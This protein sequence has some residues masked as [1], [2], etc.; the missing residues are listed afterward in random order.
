MHHETLHFCVSLILLI[1]L[2]FYWIAIKLFILDFDTAKT[3]IRLLSVIYNVPK[4]RSFIFICRHYCRLSEAEVVRFYN[5]IVDRNA[6]VVASDYAFR[7]GWIG[8][9]PSGNG[10][11]I[12]LALP[13]RWPAFLLTTVAVHEMFHLIR[14]VSGH[15]SLT[16]ERLRSIVNIQRFLLTLREECIVWRKTWRV[17][18]IGSLILL[19]AGISFP[20]MYGML[21]YIVYG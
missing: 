9:I 10:S 17:D 5:L 20:I 13:G 12:G 21:T 16:S 8:S 3:D 2:T 15:A 14:H 18:Q 4:D 6:L 19:T 7:C 11:R 1:A